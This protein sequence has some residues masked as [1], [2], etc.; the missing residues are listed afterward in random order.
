MTT[1]AGTGSG[2]NI[3]I[4]PQM[5]HRVGGPTDVRIGVMSPDIHGRRA[6]I[7]VT[8]DVAIGLA[9]DLL[10]SSDADARV[11]AGRATPAT[12]TARTLAGTH[13]GQTIRTHVPTRD[14]TVTGPLR[15]IAHSYDHTNF[16]IGACDITVPADH[17][18]T[19]NPQE[20][21]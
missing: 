4:Q 11:T 9:I 7:N 19:I 18:I 13:I 14:V 3:H 8:Q 16:C 21:S 15:W 1:H 6:Y 17:P 5:D 2:T 10:Y 20:E 12:T